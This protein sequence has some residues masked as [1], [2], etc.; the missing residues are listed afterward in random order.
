M[1]HIRATTIRGRRESL[2]VESVGPVDERELRA[3]SVLCDSKH[4]P[5]V[6]Q[7]DRPK[8]LVGTLAGERADGTNG[9]A[10]TAA[11]TAGAAMYTEPPRNEPG[12]SMQH[13]NRDR[14]ST[15]VRCSVSTASI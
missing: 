2:A 1:S 7:F 12:S 3:R 14:Q 6:G 8:R 5:I 15:G 10:S 4:G 11:P 9:R 13:G